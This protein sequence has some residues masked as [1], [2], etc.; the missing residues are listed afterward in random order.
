VKPWILIGSY[1][2]FNLVLISLLWGDAWLPRNVGVVVV[3]VIVAGWF[4]SAYLVF[5]RFRLTLRDKLIGWLLIFGLVGFTF[6]LRF[7]RYYLIHSWT[8]WLI[9][10]VAGFLF[11]LATF[12]LASFLE[13]KRQ[14]PATLYTVESESP[15]HV[16]HKDD[17]SD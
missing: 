3:V 8:I 17:T 11:L 1:I 16:F 2:L 14:L 7:S 10:S 4:A 9:W 6:A 5:R 13:E 12:G 15:D